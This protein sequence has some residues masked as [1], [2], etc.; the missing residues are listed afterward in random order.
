M[1]HVCPKIWILPVL[2]LLASACSVSRLLPEGKYLVRDNR[3]IITD[4]LEDPRGLADDLEDIA[5]PEPNGTFLGYHLGVR[6]YYWSQDTSKGINR[7][8]RKRVAQTPALLD[9]S[10]LRQSAADMEQ[11][12]FNK[13]YFDAKVTPE[14]NYKK[15]RT[16][17][18]KVKVSYYVQR[19]EVMTVNAVHYQLKD[20]NMYHLLLHHPR[21]KPQI[22]AGQRYDVAHILNERKRIETIL[23]NNGYYTFDRQD[24]LFQVDTLPGQHALDIY[25][26]IYPP[27][28]D[29]IHRVWRINEIYLLPDYHDRL[30]NGSSATDTLVVDGYHILYRNQIRYNPKALTQAVFMSPGAIYK[31][32]NYELTLNRFTSMRIFRFVNVDL[33]PVVQDGRH[34]LNVYIKLLPAEQREINLNLNATTSS[35]YFLGSDAGVSYTNKNL[36]NY[37]DIF[38]LGLNGGVE[39]IVDS[40]RGFRLNTVDVN[41]TAGLTFPKFLLPFKLRRVPKSHNAKTH[42]TANYNYFRRLNYYTLNNLSFTYGFDWNE[43]GYARHIL[44]PIDINFV[45]VTDTTRAFLETIQESPSLQRSFQDVLVA[46]SNYTYS[47]S[48]Q[49]KNSDHYWF[50]RMRLEMAGNTLYGLS[51]LLGGRQEDGVYQLA[52]RPFSQFVKPEL[53]FK[54]LTRLGPEKAIVF[55]VLGGIGIAYGNSNLMPYI[56]QFT[57]GGSNSIRAFRIRELGP[58][59]AVSASREKGNNVFNDRSGEIKLEGNVEYRFPISSMFK[60]ALFADFGN[61]WMRQDDPEREGEEFAFDRFYKEIALG[62]GVGLRVDFSFFIARVDVGFP[63][64]DPRLPEGERWRWAQYGIGQ[65]NPFSGYWRQDNM[66]LQLA[67]GYPF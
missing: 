38:N 55:R 9:T 5:L 42:I 23:Q 33:K 40:A 52:N 30:F 54:Y 47:Y 31:K 4:T 56:K 51:A 43:F 25:V 37:T 50:Y 12:L 64:R 7:W 48:S 1:T 24:L 27:K 67:I 32:T 63:V 11:Y 10:L 36:F 6:A 3:V 17:N 61:I 29:S 13:G 18:Q 2:L 59:S 49:Q 19:E 65:I 62:L 34:L 45:R 53:E 66:R 35:L 14:V 39:M 20:S 16:R 57:I 41:A 58:G 21:S 44:N 8:L 22:Q 26:S 28:N 15:H 60:G 46:G